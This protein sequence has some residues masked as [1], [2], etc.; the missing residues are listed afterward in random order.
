MTPCKD[1]VFQATFALERAR[2]YRFRYLN[3]TEHW[4]NRWADDYLPGDYDTDDSVVTTW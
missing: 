2:S 4:E 3:D 1:G